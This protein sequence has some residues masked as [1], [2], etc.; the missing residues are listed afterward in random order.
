MRSE[1]FGTRLA[2]ELKYPLTDTV[3][4]IAIGCFTLLTL[5]AIEAGLP[6][7]WLAAILVPALWRYLLM[8]LEARAHGRP[9]PVASLETFNPL[10]SFWSLTPLVLV[11]LSIWGSILLHGRVSPLAGQAFAAVVMAILP[12]SAAV[13]ALTRSP[14]ESL[15]P[16]AIV[17]MVVACGPAYVL[18]P[19][20]LVLGSVLI[21][22]VHAVGAPAIVDVAAGYYTAFLVF[23]LTGALLRWNGVQFSIS[24]PEPLAAGEGLVHAR[25]VQSRRQV[26]T[27][28]YGFFARDNRSGGMAHI[29]DALA[30]EGDDDEAWRWYLDETFRWESKDGA[31]MLGQLYLHRLLEEGRDIEA[32][33]LMSR[34]LLEDPRFRPL[35]DDRDAAHEV[36]ERLRRGD[37]VRAMDLA[38][39]SAD[40]PETS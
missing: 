6:G 24:I 25:R 29:R 35:A 39:P 28:A 2:R 37:L 4:L 5:L 9:T 22:I 19:M 20:T 33:K 18:A 26:L 32:V 34:C 1:S 13:L 17:R 7:L 14:L 16:R 31:L 15:D 38:P 8:L 36:A 3:V 11:A 40:H 30:R 27:H 12:A 10:D 23:T 21:A